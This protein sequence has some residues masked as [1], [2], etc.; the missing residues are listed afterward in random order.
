MENIARVTSHIAEKL[1]RE[2]ADDRSRRVL[3]VV[4]ARDG[5]LWVRDAGGGWWRTYL[6]IEGTHSLELI[7]PSDAARV[8]GKSIGRFQKQLADLGAGGSTRPFRVF[9]TWKSATAGFTMPWKQIRVTGSGKPGRR[10]PL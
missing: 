9:T 7:S 5:K 1:E 3:S 8:L 6:F 10:L 4:P 2:G